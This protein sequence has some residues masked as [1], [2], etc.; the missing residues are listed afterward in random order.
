MTCTKPARS[1]SPTVSTSTVLL[2]RNVGSPVKSFDVCVHH[3]SCSVRS[4]LRRA[5]SSES[6][7]ATAMNR[8]SSV[9]PAVEPNQP[10]APGASSSAHLSSACR[11]SAASAT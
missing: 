2:S 10:V 3:W 7:R 4:L 9:T 11:A 8:P 5:A 1:G 6:N